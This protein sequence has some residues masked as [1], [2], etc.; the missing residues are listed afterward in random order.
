MEVFHLREHRSV[1]RWGLFFVS[2][3][4][5]AIVFTGIGFGVSTVFDGPRDAV[6]A[7]QSAAPKVTYTQ[8]M[9]PM[10]RPVTP[11]GESPF[12]AIVERSSDAV[13][14]ITSNHRVQSRYHDMY[15]DFW[16]KFFRMP[17]REQVI[18]SFGSGFVI[19]D[20]G[21]IVTNNHVVDNAEDIKVTL[22]DKSSFKATV[23]GTD[24]ATDL[25]VIKIDTDEKL[26]T[27]DFGNSGNMKVGDWVIAIGN[28]FPTLG[29]DRTV[30][31]GV[32][33]GKGRSQLS[34]GDETP[35]YQD[36]IQTDASINPGNSGGPLLNL[37]GRV[38]GVNSAIASPSGGSVGIGFA[39]PSDLAK[40]VVTQIITEGKVSRGYLGVLPRNLT[41]DEAEMVGLDKPTGV[42][43]DE[44]TPGSPAAQ[45]G[46]EQDD[47]ITTFNGKPVSGEQDFRLKVAAAG[48]GDK[49]QLGIIR[50]GKP[51]QVSVVLGDR[52]T[53]MAEYTPTRTTPGVQT[54]DSEDVSESWLGMTVADCTQDLAYKLGVDYHEG[55]IVVR[56]EQGSPADLKGIVPGT[57]IMEIDYVP[58]KGKADFEKVAKDLKDRDRAIAFHVFDVS[59]RIGYV[60]IKP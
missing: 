8:A 51:K 27:V 47:V 11:T 13:V 45:G 23:V 16:R 12:V 6:A 7:T 1:T 31:V 29:L 14:N 30:T 57:I 53:A 25:A 26:S 32:V 37:E 43:I 52:E 21:Y 44:V 46:L 18:P 9:G 22:P 34:F 3:T 38:V 36:Y 55:A 49:V 41:T 2:L 50:K 54:P 40:E 24:P 33:S 5:T 59:G 35:I 42:Y 20:D 58:I 60:A 39:I 15:D 10:E 48:H 56:V 17:N 4:L 19:R 28:P